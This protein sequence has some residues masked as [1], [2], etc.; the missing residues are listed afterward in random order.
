L[1]V[2]SFRSAE[3]EIMKDKQKALA[4]RATY[5][6]VTTTRKSDIDQK[7]EKQRTYEC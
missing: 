7:R 1:V 2:A 5:S 4:E 6:I 3:N